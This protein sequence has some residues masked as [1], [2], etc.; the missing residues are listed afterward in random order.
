MNQFIFLLIIIFKQSC[1]NIYILCVSDCVEG[2]DEAISDEERLQHELLFYSQG[3]VD[4]LYLTGR[5][6]E[7][8]HIWGELFK[9]SLA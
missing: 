3:P 7:L 6:L 2:W 8:L 4:G 9:A 1:N 5:T